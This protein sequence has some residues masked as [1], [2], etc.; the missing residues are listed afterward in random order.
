MADLAIR[1]VEI[2]VNDAVL[3]GASE[4]GGYRV[5]LNSCFPSV[6]EWPGAD[7]RIAAVSMRN[8]DCADTSLYRLLLT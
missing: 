2:A 6:F 3:V 7:R 5:A 4:G 1:W 8:P